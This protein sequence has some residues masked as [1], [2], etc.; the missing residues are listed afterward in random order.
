[1]HKYQAITACV[2][3]HKDGK[4]FLAKRAKTKKFLPDK[5]ELPGGH[6]EFGE[7][8]EAGLTREIREEFN[9][10]VEIGDIFYAFIYVSHDGEKHTV[11]IDY[12][13]VMKDSKQKITLNPED[14]SEYK[15]VSEE[16]ARRYFPAGDQEGI[17][18]KRGFEILKNN[19]IN[20]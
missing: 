15:W 7:S 5:F 17:A 2:F 20:N 13:A 6:I 19:K 12:F 10:E 16:E 1:M 3:L 11:E 9:I 4:L 8:L 18:I 14:H